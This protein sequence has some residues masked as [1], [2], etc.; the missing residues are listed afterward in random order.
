MGALHAHSH[1]Q[2]QSFEF[3]YLN[4]NFRNRFLGV[5]S[6]PSPSRIADS[7]CRLRLP[8]R[9]ADSDFRLGLPT[10]ISDSDYQM[11]GRAR[12][13]PAARGGPRVDEARTG[14]ALRLG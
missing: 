2:G 8:T 11:L 10:R 7:D 4:S 9:I 14:A 5:Q 12:E 13:E 1:A 6:V 3:K